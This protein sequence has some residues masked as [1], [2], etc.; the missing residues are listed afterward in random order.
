[1]IENSL[2]FIVFLSLGIYL[3]LDSIFTGSGILMLIERSSRKNRDS[4]IVANIPFWDQNRTWLVFAGVLLWACFPLAYSKMVQALFAP[5]ILMVLGFAVQIASFEMRN[6]WKKHT[7][8]IDIFFGVSSLVVAISHGI[9]M[10]FIVGAFAMQTYLVNEY[11]NYHIPF[12]FFCILLTIISYMLMAMSVLQYKLSISN[13]DFC[14]KMV[15]LIHRCVNSIMILVCIIHLSKPIV[16]I[17]QTS[18]YAYIFTIAFLVVIFISF[19]IMKSNTCGNRIKQIIFVVLLF[20]S[21]FAGLLF[22][23]Y[24]YIVPIQDRFYDV[25]TGEKSLFL[26]STSI[27]SFIIIVARLFVN[28]HKIFNVVDPNM[29][30]DY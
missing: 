17:F 22:V 2:Y 5:I 1:M 19:M 23:A 7:D 24:P 26:I 16:Y 28:N 20:L 10:S 14:N 18:F 27:I 21:F 12:T 8:K 25:I 11:I 13:V 15:K 3:I 4:I 9:M 30:N 29:L 6:K